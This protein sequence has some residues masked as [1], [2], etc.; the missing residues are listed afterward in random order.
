MK[1]RERETQTSENFYGLINQ[2]GKHPPLHFCNDPFQVKFLS[3][4]QNNILN[5]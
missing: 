1:E 2:F 5:F 4:W 3:T